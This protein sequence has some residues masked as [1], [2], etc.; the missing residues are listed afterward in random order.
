MNRNTVVIPVSNHADITDRCLKALLEESKASRFLIIDNGSEVPYQTWLPTIR[1]EDNKGCL[2]GL[3]QGLEECSTEF[4]TF[5]HNDVLVHE[6]AWDLVVAKAFDDHPNLGLLGFFGAPGVA[7][8]GGRVGSKSRM[9]GTEWGTLWNLHGGLLERDELMP[10]S[11][12]DSLCMIFRVD[13]LRQI[14][15]PD[16]WPPHHW[17]DRL[18]CVKMIKAGYDV[19]TIG[20]EFDHRGG[21]STGQVYDDFVIKWG[22]DNNIQEG[23]NADIIMY[24]KGLQLFL[25]EYSHESP[26]LVGNDWDYTWRTMVKHE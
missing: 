5:M 19:A 20:I 13:Y 21:S 8:N 15:I 26:L 9:L 17:F 1:N 6:N 22:E 3:R 10:S 11:V 14:G 16:D 4:L 7:P 18:F 12:L 2:A 24:N 25:N 23:E